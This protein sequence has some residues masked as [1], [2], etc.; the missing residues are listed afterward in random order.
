VDKLVQSGVAEYLEFRSVRT[1]V[2]WTGTSFQ[3]VPCNAAEL[4]STPK[5][6]DR[7]GATETLEQVD[8]ASKHRSMRDGLVNRSLTTAERRILLRFI[9]SCRRMF[10]AEDLDMTKDFREFMDEMNLTVHLKEVVLYGV[11]LDQGGSP[12]SVGTAV[13]RLRQYMESLGRYKDNKA[14]LY[15]VYGSSDIS[16]AYCRLAAVYQAVY[17]LSVGLSSPAVEP[18]E[19]QFIVHTSLGDITARHVICGAAYGDLTIDSSVEAF[20]QAQF[21]HGYIVST[22]ELFPEADDDPVLLSVPP[23][24]FNNVSP[25]YI[26]QLSSSTNTVPPDHFLYHVSFQIQPPDDPSAIFEQLSS[27]LALHQVFRGS[28]V[29]QSNCRSS[30]LGVL[31]LPDAQGDFEFKTNFE[32]AQMTFCSLEPE[33][34]FLPRRVNAEQSA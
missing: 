28:Y 16:Q 25:I 4:Y 7:R 15:P 12:L 27:V 33:A 24:H 19:D 14:L 2:L 3:A 10:E 18:V 26:L 21:F 20:S 31:H 6:D 22:D 8:T 34:E 30:S 9:E 11:L 29:Q 1:G 23:G 17:C 32:I 5:S 13:N